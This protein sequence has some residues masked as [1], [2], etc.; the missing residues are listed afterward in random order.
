M[1][2]HAG[3]Y[4]HAVEHGHEVAG[5]HQAGAAVVIV[6]GSGTLYRYAVHNVGYL[7]TDAAHGAVKGAH[8]RLGRGVV[9]GH[10]HAVHIVD[11]EGVHVPVGVFFQHVGEIFVDPVGCGGALGIRVLDFVKT[12]GEGAVHEL[13]GP[14]DEHLA[15]DRAAEDGAY[16]GKYVLYAVVVEE[17][18]VLLGLPEKLL[19]G[20]VHVLAGVGL[21]GGELAAQDPVDLGPLV[22]GVHRPLA[23]LGVQG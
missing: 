21:A 13:I 22:Q 8:P 4:A 11:V 23:G 14:F 3:L 5:L 20:A 1:L 17:L 12:D 19:V 10:A 6:I 18:H 9:G 2:V 7:P 16:V 15:L